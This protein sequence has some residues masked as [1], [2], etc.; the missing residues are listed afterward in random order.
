[1]KVS[2]ISA[3]LAAIGFSSLTAAVPLE[4]RWSCSAYPWFIAPHH[5]RDCTSQPPAFQPT[6]GPIQD[7][8]ANSYCKPL[9][10][11]AKPEHGFGSVA[12][13]LDACPSQ[14]WQIKLYTEEDCSCPPVVVDADSCVAAPPGEHFVKFDAILVTW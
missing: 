6:S 11:P 10:D 4:Q 7:H 14:K 13:N 1:M 3:T 12:I 2:V 8:P 5:G 9:Y